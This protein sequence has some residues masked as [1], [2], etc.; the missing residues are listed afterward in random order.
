MRAHQAGSH[1]GI[2]WE[3]FTDAAI[4]ALDAEDR[5]IVFM[6]WGGPARAKKEML[7]NPKHLVLEAPH[8]SPL[9]AYRGFFGC[10]HFSK[11][12]AFLMKNGIDPIDWQIR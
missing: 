3:Q 12:N 6:L 5:P 7:H 4:R 11:C 1:K 2:G 8:P 9:S 10:R